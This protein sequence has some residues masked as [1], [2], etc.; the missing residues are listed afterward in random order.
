MAQALS[1]PLSLPLRSGGLLPA[2]SHGRT[3]LARPVIEKVIV[4]CGV[5]EDGGVAVR[6]ELLLLGLIEL[7]SCGVA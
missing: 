7:S 3:A 2:Q 5:G 4:A 6:V 1:V